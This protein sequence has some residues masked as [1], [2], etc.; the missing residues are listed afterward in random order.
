[1]ARNGNSDTYAQIS[2]IKQL[3]PNFPENRDALVNETSIGEYLRH[4]YQVIN[5]RIANY[6]ETPILVADSPCSYEIL[7]EIQA[8]YAADIVDRVLNPGRKVT[9]GPHWGQ[10]AYRLLNE[11][12]PDPNRGEHPTTILPDA[13]YIGSRIH[14]AVVSGSTGDPVFTK[15]GDQW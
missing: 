15:A 6:Y 7:R 12:A 11:I 14:N 9:E 8:F 5:G 3:F 13:T 1:M 4:S 2:D 10:K